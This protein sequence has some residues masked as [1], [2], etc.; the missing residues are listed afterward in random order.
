[1]EELA[2]ALHVGRAR[3]LRSRSVARLEGAGVVEVLEGG[4]V[5]LRDDWLD[6]LDRERTLSGEKLAGNL[7]RQRHEREREAYRQHLA[8]REQSGGSRDRQ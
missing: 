2:G 5:R 4:V 3:D 6:A 1:V 8:E 7:D